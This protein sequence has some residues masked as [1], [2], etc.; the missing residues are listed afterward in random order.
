MD[1]E[2]SLMKIFLAAGTICFA[3]VLPFS[4]ESL[5]GG[6]EKGHLVILLD[7]AQFATRSSESIP[8]VNDFLLTVKDGD[9]EPVYEGSF[10]DMPEDLAVAPGTYDISV[11]SC[12]FKGPAFASPLYGDDQSVVVPSGGREVVSLL[13]TQLNSGVRLRIGPDFLESFPEA[14]LF[15]KS[16]DGK[17]MYSYK[18][19]RIAYFNPGA[20]SLVMDNAGEE[21]NLLTRQ[22]AAREILSVGISAPASAGGGIGGIKVSVDTS[23]VWTGTDV[24]IGEGEAGESEDGAVSVQ[25][26]REMAGEEDVWVS[27]YIVGV[28]KST[29]HP[30]FD[31]PYTS[32]T[33]VL[34]ADSPSADNKADC[35]SV[36]LKKGSLRDAL[37]LVDNP[38]NAGKKVSLKGD[39]VE[40]Y[41]GI[42]GMKSVS[43]YSIE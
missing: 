26:A 36:E 16:P 34:I 28:F 8:D 19:K 10:G 30:I 4:C 24:S 21:S 43:D 13:C 40:A 7:G 32:A 33:N 12:R 23:R 6:S 35:L 20:V 14:V 25:S 39:I 5:E 9:G 3:A 11:R 31:P 27:G 29:N 22:I 38:D 2:K 41:Y 42:P 15:V 17:L 37:N 1:M 18:E